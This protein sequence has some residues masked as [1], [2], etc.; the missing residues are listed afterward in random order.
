MCQL[1]KLINLFLMNNYT[2]MSNQKHLRIMAT[3]NLSHKI[4]PSTDE[5]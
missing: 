4:T 2:L 3:K 1:I 5:K